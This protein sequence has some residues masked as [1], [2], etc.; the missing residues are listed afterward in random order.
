MLDS[1]ASVRPLSFHRPQAGKST[2]LIWFVVRRLCL[3]L[4]TELQVDRYSAVL[5]HADD[6]SRF[7]FLDNLIPHLELDHPPEGLSRIWVLVN[8][9]DDLAKSAAVFC[10]D[11]PFF[12]VETVSPRQS[13]FEGARELAFG[14]FHMKTWS[15]SEVLRAYMDPS[16]GGISGLHLLQSLV[17]TGPT[18]WHL[19]D[20]KSVV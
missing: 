13:Q 10:K 1:L 12:V 4:P 11:G 9:N 7:Q 15:F 3:G 8:S 14:R 17:H 6:T 5:F 20:R 16:S 18:L 19:K 2:F